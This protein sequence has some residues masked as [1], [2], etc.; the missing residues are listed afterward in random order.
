[1]KVLL[2]GKDWIKVQK[3]LNRQENRRYRMPRRT[4]SLLSGILKC[5]NC[6]SCLRPKQSK[7]DNGKRFYYKCELKE[8]SNGHRCNIKN[9]NGND[10]DKIVLQKVKELIA[11]NS[12]IYKALKDIVN[13]V[14]NEEVERKSKIDRLKNIL[15]KNDREIKSLVEKMIYV[16]PNNVKYLSDKITELKNSNIEIEKEMEKLNITKNQICDKETAKYILHIID[17]H[18]DNFEKLDVLEQR[19]L[20]KLLVDSVVTD[21]ENLTINLFGVNN[22]DSLPTGVYRK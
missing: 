12:E 15:N 3:I 21:G 14:D 8:R 20:I 2:V 5:S 6:G 11:P 22:N 18:F 10:I 7:N 17:N 4:K 19:D 1:M 9:L 16:D 13:L